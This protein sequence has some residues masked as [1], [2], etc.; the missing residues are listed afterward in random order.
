[1]KEWPMD[2]VPTMEELIEPLIPVIHFVYNLKRKEAGDIPYYGFDRG[3]YGSEDMLSPTKR[4]SKQHLLEMET[5]YGPDATL[6]EILTV[7][8]EV[9]IEWGRLIARKER[10]LISQ[11]EIV[12]FFTSILG[13]K[14]KKL[15]VTIQLTTPEKKTPQYQPDPNLQQWPKDKAPRVND[16]C[17]PL[18]KTFEAAF[19]MTRKNRDKD[20]PYGGYGLP[21]EIVEGWWD[22]QE[23]LLAKNLKYAEEDQGYSAIEIILSNALRL[24]WVLGET[25]ERNQNLEHDDVYRKTLIFNQQIFER[26]K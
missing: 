5:K 7:A 22:P 12:D 25:I 13:D 8:I 4:L 26:G 23:E 1:M 3:E 6:H 10:R 9:G 17:K 14:A 21:E 11:K 15:G 18:V 24:G 20:V 19:R 2:R 16:V